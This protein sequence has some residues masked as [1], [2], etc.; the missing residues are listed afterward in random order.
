M[1]GIKEDTSHLSFCGKGNP[2]RFHVIL[3]GGFPLAMHL[4]ET[5]GPG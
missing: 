4:R 2:S 3:G 5:D 1:Y